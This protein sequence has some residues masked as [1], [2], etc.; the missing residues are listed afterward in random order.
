MGADVRLRHSIDPDG[1]HVWIT[2]GDRTLKVAATAIKRF[3]WGVLNDL[4]PDDVESLIG[5]MTEATTAPNIPDGFHK[6]AVLVTL[7][8][9]LTTAKAIALHLHMKRSNVSVILCNHR[10]DG[11]VS[12]SADGIGLAGVWSL[13]TE[14]KLAVE[15][16][17]RKMSA[18]RVLEAAG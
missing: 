1:E 10:K 14:G 9:G 11:Y 5:E 18:A 12:V 17:D 3:A 13:T 15:T 6:W 8:D 16:A 2:A 7:R 4:C